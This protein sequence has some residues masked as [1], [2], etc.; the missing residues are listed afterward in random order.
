MAQ[1]HARPTSSCGGDKQGKSKKKK[2][3]RREG[4]YLC[5]QPIKTMQFIHSFNV[6]IQDRRT[7]SGPIK[8]LR[9]TQLKTDPNVQKY[10]DNQPSVSFLLAEPF[11][12]PLLNTIYK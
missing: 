11:I 1:K 12:N 2:K 7:C 10:A 8:I 4:E 9:H 6:M 3:V 5:L